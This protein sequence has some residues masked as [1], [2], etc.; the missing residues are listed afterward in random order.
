[1]SRPAPLRPHPLVIDEC[2]CMRPIFTVLEEGGFE[3]YKLP[4][5]VGPGVADETWLPIVTA[6]G[7]A[8]ITKDKYITKTRNE[9]LAVAHCGAM[10]FVMAN[11]SLKADTMADILKQA[12]PGI[13]KLC[14]KEPAPF[15][16][17]LQVEGPIAVQ[18]RAD[19]LKRF[20][21]D[22]VARLR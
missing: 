20:A 7:W 22:T 16:A 8:V 9:L 19:D 11:G 5:V 13:F 14:R 18:W 15:I 12:L 4:T 1:M 21:Q 2:V 10:L 6:N 3:Y 17:R